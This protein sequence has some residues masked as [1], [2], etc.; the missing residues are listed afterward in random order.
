M[1]AVIVHV[2]VQQTQ[3]LNQIIWPGVPIMVNVE[4][5]PIWRNIHVT[6]LEPI[7]EIT[8]AYA[9]CQQVGHEFKKIVPLWMIN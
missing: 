8:L 7:I 9:Y 1:D 5:P 6:N 2:V 3:P 4:Q